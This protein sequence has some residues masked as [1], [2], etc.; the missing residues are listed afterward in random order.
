MLKV[1]TFLNNSVQEIIY[2][3]ECEKIAK[4]NCVGSQTVLQD[5]ELKRI[6]LLIMSCDGK[7]NRFHKI[8]Q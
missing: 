2:V 3:F 6:F 8:S 1:I 7:I 4:R 5:K